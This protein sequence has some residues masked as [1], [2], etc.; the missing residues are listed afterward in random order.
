MTWHIILLR[1]PGSALKDQHLDM[2]RVGSCARFVM[3][4]HQSDL[5]S[6]FIDASKTQN[7]GTS[8]TK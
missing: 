3:T 2:R 6:K 4:D 5:I 7:R 1:K 8:K